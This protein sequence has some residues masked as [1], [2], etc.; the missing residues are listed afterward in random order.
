M[1][2]RLLSGKPKAAKER[3]AA[4]PG[5]LTYEEARDILAE[6]DAAARQA[7]AQHPQ[8][9]PEMLYYLASDVEAD[10]RLSVV[11][12]PNTPQPA[13]RLLAND[14]DD[15]VRCELA[16]K[17][18]TLLPGLD[19]TEQT[20]LR[21]QAIGVLETLAC[22]QLPRVRQIVAEELKSADT[23]PRHVVM[24]LARDVELAVCAPILE[25]SPLLNTDDLREIIA[26]SKVQGALAAIAR[27]SNLDAA[28]SDD[29]AA[30]LDVPAVAALL[31]N[32]SAQIREETLDAII[33]N[34][35]SIEQWHEPIVMRPNLSIRAMRRISTFVASSLIDRLIERKGLPDDI[36]REL[37]ERVVDRIR[38]DE[39]APVED[40]DVQWQA[41]RIFD[42]GEITDVYVTSLLEKRRK[43]LVIELLSLKAAL[44]REIVK[45]IIEIGRPEAVTALGWQAGLS[46]RTAMLMQTDLAS[47]SP[48]R[49]LNAKGGL[50]FPLTEEDMKWQL[51]IYTKGMV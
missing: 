12:N 2:K 33:D 15:E 31:A 41:Q 19:E 32:K 25:Y 44:P 47:V 18:G 51:D 5:S 49:R 3:A 43:S 13:C 42:R 14:N 21:E 38:S 16:R 7:L 48:A 40:E 39:F 34:A 11:R 28:V 10:V 46:M 27:R 8:A 24:Q 17:I 35:A 1:L 23:I 29:I 6:K 22:D 4:T 20:K 30:T 9:R 37:R 45:K 26:T 36:V 50:D